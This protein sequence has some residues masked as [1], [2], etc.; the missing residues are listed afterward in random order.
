MKKFFLFLFFCCFVSFGTEIKIMF[1]DKTVKPASRKFLDFSYA[2]QTDPRF[3]KGSRLTPWKY[4]GTGHAYT[5][6]GAGSLPADTMLEHGILCRKGKFELPLPD[7]KYV[8]HLYLGD[9]LVGLFR[10]IRADNQVAL[11]IN[12]RPIISKTYLPKDCFKEWLK[13]EE[14][15]FSVKD[16][17][18]DRIVKPVLDEIEVETEV[19]N[20]KLVIEMRNIYL[21]AMTLTD[22]RKQMQVINRKVEAERRKEFASRYPWKPKKNEPMPVYGTK[23]K[24]RGFLL[25]QKYGDD[26]VYPWS[27]PLARELTDTI[28][29]FAAQNEQELLRFGIIPLVELK[30]FTVE[31]GDFKK[32]DAVLRMKDNADL[33]QERY[34]EYGSTLT[35]GKID[36]MWRLDPRSAVMIKPRAIDCEVGTPRMY[37]L[38]F[39]VPENA[40]PGDYYAPLSFYSA[41]KKIGEAK[42]RLKVLPFKLDRDDAAQFSFQ[43]AY[44]LWPLTMRQAQKDIPENARRVLRFHRKYGF[45]ASHF[46]GWSGLCRPNYRVGHIEGKDGQRHFVQTEQEK[47]NADFWFKLYRQEG[48][49]SFISIQIMPYFLMHCGWDPGRGW[50][51]HNYYG[52]KG[53][54]PEVLKKKRSD[55]I[56][57]MKDIQKVF[58]DHKGV[59]PDVYWFV[60]GEP[61]NF[62][63]AGVQEGLKANQMVREMGGKSFALINGKWAGK[64]YPEKF[65]YILSTPYTPISDEFVN[66]IKKNGHIFGSHN[67]GDSR[68]AAGWHFWRLGGFHKYQET[69]LYVNFVRPYAYLPWNY[70]ISCV[71]PGAD[72]SLVP[73]IYLFNYRDGMEDYLYL[74]T[75]ENKIAAA[76]KRGETAK[77]AKAEKFLKEMHDRINIDMRSYLVTQ[78]KAFEGAGTVKSDEWNSVSF[79]RLRWQ[80]AQLIMELK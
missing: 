13:G 41:G 29:V 67:T 30:Q 55:V 43:E 17:I 47:K 4:T 49:A 42:L 8:V 57:V 28:R 50:I 62:G 26:K 37:T 64:Y 63:L 74:H 53:D 66:R 44:A 21:T 48:N 56:Q 59:Y 61:D 78:I 36:D 6:D 20:G 3:S 22:S 52:R 15:L 23:E 25:F 79:E 40:R 24:E 54:S 46:T 76:K 9:W 71:L 12:G 58:D 69:V 72:G 35:S 1:G 33:W 45:S 31:I 65:D 77:A 19:T 38:D 68:F 27:R 5:M 34:K 11:S 60:S 2:D 14:Y 39:H 32:H 70:Q 16:S 80:L 7:G 73:T 75:L 18:W 10:F 51:S